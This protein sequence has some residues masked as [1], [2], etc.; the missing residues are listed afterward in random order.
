MRLWANIGFPR[1]LRAVDH[2]QR[3]V[4]ASAGLTPGDYEAYASQVESLF[5][6]PTLIALDE[7]GIPFQLA[8][9]IAP[10]LQPLDDL[11]QVL[12]RLKGLLLDDLGLLPF[13][14]EVLEDAC[15]YL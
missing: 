7:Y 14:R 2:I 15:R 4:F 11:D 9:K 5:H 12:I 3:Y 10:E 8:L 1:L 6:E 13:E